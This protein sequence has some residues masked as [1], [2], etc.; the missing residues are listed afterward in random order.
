MAS[1][2]EKEANTTEKRKT[3]AGILWKRL[4][5]NMLLQ[6]DVAQVTYKNKGL[7]ESPIANPGIDA[8]TDALRPVDSKYWF[9]LSDKKGTIHYAI[10][11]DAHLDNI[12]KYLR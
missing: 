6:V 12:E 10:D 7:P 2:L 11:Y 1:I 9:Y 5:N 4:D 8:I 3:I